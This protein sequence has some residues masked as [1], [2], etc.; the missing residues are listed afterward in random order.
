MLACGPAGHRGDIDEGV[1]TAAIN[2][3]R[4]GVVDMAQVAPFD[5]D[6][7]LAFTGY[8]TD[9]EIRDATGGIWPAGEDTRIP[10]DSRQ[11]V[12]FLHGEELA[13]WAILNASPTDG[14]GVLFQDHAVPIPRDRARFRSVPTFKTVDGDEIYH[15]T[16]LP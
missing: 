6:R 1:R 13:A 2:A 8:T 4:G 14:T 10:Y 5:W 3:G 7:M 16:I 15:L 9:D 11:L 12:V